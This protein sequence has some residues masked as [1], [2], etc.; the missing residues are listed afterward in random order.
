VTDLLDK[1]GIVLPEEPADDPE[2]ELA[3]LISLE[4]RR[5]FLYAAVI[6]L[7]NDGVL[8]IAVAWRSSASCGA[9]YRLSC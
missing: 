1:D 8:R 6:S 3:S 4:V 5:V 9:R 7:P 2:D